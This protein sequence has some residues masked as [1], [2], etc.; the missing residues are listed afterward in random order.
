MELHLLRRRADDHPSGE[1]K[2]AQARS[3]GLCVWP[4]VELLRH[5]S[6]SLMQPLHLYRLRLIINAPLDDF[7]LRSACY[8]D[9]LT[10][11]GAGRVAHMI[12]LL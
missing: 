11:S 1:R 12:G 10:E 9:G 4:I 8:S 5:F 2:S 3:D 6:D 7:N